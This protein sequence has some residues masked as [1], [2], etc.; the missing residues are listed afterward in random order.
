[1]VSVPPRARLWFGALVD[2]DRAEGHRNSRDGRKTGGPDFVGESSRVGKLFDG[3]VQVNIGCA[4]AGNGAGDER[5]D[6]P[7]IEE[8]KRT[9]P[10]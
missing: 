9:K 5:E 6:F 8:I 2:R 3:F 1:M 7:Q 10:R 4:I